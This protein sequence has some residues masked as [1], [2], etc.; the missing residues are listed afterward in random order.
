MESKVTN[1]SKTKPNPLEWATLEPS[2]LE[3]EIAK[4]RFL[5]C[6]YYFSCLE[7]AVNYHWNGFTCY[8]CE[9]KE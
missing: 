7:V 2:R 5:N 3:E 6:P 8:W 9:R 4:H 1:E